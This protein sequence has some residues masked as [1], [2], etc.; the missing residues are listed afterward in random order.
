MSHISFS[1]M[2]GLGNCFILADDTLGGLSQ[3]LSPP[4]LARSVCDRNFGIGADGLIL[5]Q[6]SDSADLR[7]RIWN[8]DGSEAE[9]CGNGVRCFARFAVEKGLTSSRVLR[10][11]TLAGEIR[12]DYLVDGRVRVDMGRPRFESADVIHGTRTPIRVSHE[13]RDY[14]FVSM[15]NPHAVTFVKDFDLDWRSIGA[16]MEHHRAFPNKTNVHF[17]RINGPRSATV[18]VWER[19]CGETLACGTGACAVAVAAAVDG[20]LERAPVEIEL[21]GG[22]LDIEWQPDDAVIMTGPAQLVCDGR[23]YPNLS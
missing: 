2:Q 3:A 14:L 11:E 18:K 23:Y 21:P 17:A 9:M 20:R 7:M 19:G 8:E 4:D 16:E 6:R 5:V 13:E 22:K 1:K 12:T 15:G 10:I